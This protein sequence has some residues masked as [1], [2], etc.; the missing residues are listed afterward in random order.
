MLRISM[1]VC[2]CATLKL[3]WGLG[4]L[5]LTMVPHPHIYIYRSL[6]LR[7]TAATRPCIVGAASLTCLNDSTVNLPGHLQD[8]S[9]THILQV[10]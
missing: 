5:V 7:Q 4:I 8:L 9:H 1:C 6:H 2:E 10:L 3:V